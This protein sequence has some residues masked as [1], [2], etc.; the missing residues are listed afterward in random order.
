M[1]ILEIIFPII[2]TNIRTNLMREIGIIDLMIGIEIINKLK[3]TEKI[4]AN[5]EKSQE[6][7]VQTTLLIKI[8]I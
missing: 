4:E 1:K 7:K 8:K 5:Q 2:K 3:I 6:V